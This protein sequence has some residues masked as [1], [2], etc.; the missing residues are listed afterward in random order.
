MS[1]NL[2]H[3]KNERSFQPFLGYLSCFCSYVSIMDHIQSIIIHGLQCH[4]VNPLQCGAVPLLC[5]NAYTRGETTGLWKY[6]AFAR[7]LYI[8][9]AQVLKLLLVLYNAL[10]RALEL[11][12]YPCTF[13][14]PAITRQIFNPHV[15]LW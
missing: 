13:H 15:L 11:S 1:T 9:L 4:V 12:L 3:C 7:V 6:N 14:I 5:I 8:T 2:Y 10:E